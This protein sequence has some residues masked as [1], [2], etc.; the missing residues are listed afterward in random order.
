M[1]LAMRAAAGPGASARAR[2]SARAGGSRCVL[3]QHRNGAVADVDAPALDDETLTTTERTR[4]LNPSTPKPHR[5]TNLASASR[6]WPRHHQSH[7]AI[8][9]LTGPGRARRRAGSVVAA[10][11]AP[12]GGNNPPPSSLSDLIAF[13]SEVG[14]SGSGSSDHPE[15][16]DDD[17]PTV[18]A[19]AIIGRATKV[20]EAARAALGT[21]DAPPSPAAAPSSAPATFGAAAPSPPSS[22]PPV[23]S[24]AASGDLTRAVLHGALGRAAKS[25]RGGGAAAPASSSSSHG[26]GGTSSTTSS[27]GMPA[28]ASG[29][30]ARD[31]EDVFLNT[32]PPRMTF[33]GEEGEG[34]GGGSSGSSGGSSGSGGPIVTGGWPAAAASAPSSSPPSGL[35]L[36][37]ALGAALLQ[38]QSQPSPAAAA[39]AFADDD[40]ARPSPLFN[41]L[42]LPS[43]ATADAERARRTTELPPLQS[44]LELTSAFKPPERGGGGVGAAEA[45]A[46]TTTTTATTTVGRDLPDGSGVLPDG[47][48]YEKSSGV[49]YGANGY[50]R[51]WRTLRGVTLVPVAADGSALTTGSVAAAAA[52]AQKAGSTQRMA[53][54]EFEETWWE[55][56]DYAG[57]RVM[58]AEKRGRD[59]QGGQWRERWEE[60]LFYASAQLDGVVERSAH[61]W[62]KAPLAPGS[63]SDATPDE[64]E[65]RWDE[66]YHASGRASKSADK[67]GKQGANVWHERWG[68][69]YDGAGACVK[70]TDKWAE[71]LTPDGLGSEQ[72]GDKWHEEFADGKGRKNGEVWSV[73]GDGA[74]YQRWWGEE[75]PGGGVVRRHG[76]STSG[77]AWDD[78]VQMDTYYNPIPHFGYQLAVEHSPQLRNVPLRPPEAQVGG[79]GG[80]GGGGNGDDD[81][82]FGPGLDAL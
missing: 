67:W 16:E 41:S 64:W 15:N 1:R 31:D 24:I 34:E 28:W 27:S 58:G 73:A 11:A 57:L 78:T 21:A 29:L 75:H 40:Q 17:D 25:A 51:R 12:D 20:L 23:G 22:S 2:G 50:W 6:R 4:P 13:E 69:D 77:E 70:W 19:Q 59:A 74:R 26:D 36:A 66:H 18:R 61:K 47:T 30:L 82:P 42:A 32:P 81:D 49:E 39:V 55:A 54:V 7:G 65:E 53:R 5:P 3:L 38:Q 10:S 80:G 52:N 33:G 56:S 68:E 71:R 14:R 8:N 60:K 46:A 44:V 45:E 72:W 48:R 62:A 79:G 37:P 63:P 43:Q 76:H 9:I 35:R